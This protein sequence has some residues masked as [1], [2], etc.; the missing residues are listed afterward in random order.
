MATGEVGGL[1]PKLGTLGSCS[2]TLISQKAA[3]MAPR[4]CRIWSA[5]SS[6][7]SALPAGRHGSASQADRKSSRMMGA[8]C[9]KSCI[10]HG[11]VLLL[12]PQPGDLLSSSEVA[13][14][15][16]QRATQAG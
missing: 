5:T 11:L 8:A 3:R 16:K 1:S 12:V 9:R 14:Q 2:P 10:V 7:S 6:V 15:V 13:A 4:C